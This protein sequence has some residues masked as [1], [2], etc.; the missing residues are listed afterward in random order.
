MNLLL[1][2]NKR[3]HNNLSEFEKK[4]LSEQLKSL[5]KRHTLL[6]EI[7]SQ[8]YLINIYVSL[9]LSYIIITR[10]NI[11]QM[12]KAS[13]WH[14]MMMNYSYLFSNVLFFFR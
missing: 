8:S 14:I 9:L 5:S 12:K 7:D 11:T 4:Y 10:I 6:D 3:E 13:M 1:K 2:V